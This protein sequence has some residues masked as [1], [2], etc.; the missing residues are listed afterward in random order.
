LKQKIFGFG[1]GY[2]LAG[3]LENVLLRKTIFPSLVVLSLRPI[4]SK[5]FIKVVDST[6]RQMCP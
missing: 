5:F 4:A 2:F 3:T 6:G 1:S